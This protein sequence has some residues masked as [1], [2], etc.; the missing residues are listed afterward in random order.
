[1]VT[2]GRFGYINIRAVGFLIERNE[3]KLVALIDK[4]DYK[5]AGTRVFTTGV[6]DF[7]LA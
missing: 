5:M 2:Y 6:I 4:S 7:Q 1:M 3:T